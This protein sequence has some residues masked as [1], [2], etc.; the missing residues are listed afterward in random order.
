MKQ[1]YALL[2]DYY[3]PAEYIRPSLL[4]AVEHSALMQ[5]VE[6]H[7]AEIEELQNVLRQKP[8]CVILFKEDRVNPNEADVRTWMS[9]EIAS[10]ISRYV[11]G[12]GSWL[13]W[14]SGLASYDK[15]GEFIS[16]LRGYFEYHPKVHQVVF[17]KQVNTGPSTASGFDILD[18]HYFVNC[19]EANTEVYLLSESIDGKSIAGWRHRFGSGKVCCF[20]PAHRIE[21]LLDPN[22]LHVL[23]EVIRW[24][25]S[26]Q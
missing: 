7:Y 16:M 18:E 20:T 3:H 22:L 6:I 17:Y 12:G 19:D 25:C 2:G 9:D 13:A 24:C 21:G 8:D 1:L 10:D 4:Q 23:G 11:S 5:E 15:D 14:H 26:D